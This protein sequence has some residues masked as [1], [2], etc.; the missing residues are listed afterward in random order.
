[1]TKTLLSWADVLDLLRQ[2]DEPNVK[3]YG[4]PTGGMIL[5]AFLKHAEAVYDPMEAT[6]I[7]DDIID[8]GATKER[9]LKMFPGRPFRALIDKTKGADDL[10]WIVFPWEHTNGPEDC[11][12]RLLEFLGEDPKRE[13]LL[14][15]PSRV[16]KAFQEMTEGKHESPAAILSKD[17]TQQCDQM[18]WLKGIS[19]TSLC[20]HHLLPFYGTATIAYIPDGK[21]VGISKLARLVGCYAKRLQLQERM[22]EEI[23]DALVTYVNPRGAGVHVKAHHQCMGCRGVR[24][25]NA[26]MVTTCLRGVLFTDAMAREEFNASVS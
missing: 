19:F 26:E 17:F 18:I 23:A 10:G 11:I 12:I 21:V 6:L 1:M 22:T 25:I 24:Q 4:V 14:E 8:S 13:G 16:L 3:I 15:T 9:Y 7:L 5:T 2:Y 20:E